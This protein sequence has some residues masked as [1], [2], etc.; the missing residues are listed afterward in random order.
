LLQGL[1]NRGRL[2]DSW[3]IEYYAKNENEPRYQVLSPMNQD[4]LQIYIDNFLT[5]NQEIQEGSSNFFDAIPAEIEFIKFTDS[6]IY[7][8]LKAYDI[9]KNNEVPFESDARDFIRENRGRRI[10]NDTWFPYYL[11]DKICSYLSELQKF[12]KEQLD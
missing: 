5:Q 12:R 1:L 8:E 11:E 3:R 10:R 7:P 9:D 2:T 6:T 4:Q